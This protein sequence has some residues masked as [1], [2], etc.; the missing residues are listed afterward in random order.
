MPFRRL[1]PLTALR[2]FEAVA[3]RESIKDAADELCV[4][5]GAVSQQIRKLEEDLGMPLLIRRN[6]AIEVTPPARVLA[7]GLTDALS[8]IREAV[9]AAQPNSDE[10]CLVVACPPAFAMKWLVPRLCTF[11]DAHPDIDLRMLPHD[12]LAGLAVQGADVQI[13]LGTEPAE[14]LESESLGEETF[15][16]LMSPAFA[17][18]HGIDT[19]ADLLRVPLVSYKH[20]GLFPEAPTWVD[21]FGARH[22]PEPEDS[23]FFGFG[24]QVEQAID[25]AVSGLGAVL[26]P[27]V[28]AARDLAA[29]RLVAPWGPELGTGLSYEIAWPER[30]GRSANVRAFRQWLVSEFTAS[31]EAP[32]SP[33]LTA[34]VA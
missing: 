32:V 20:D 28:L 12:D 11:V 27:Q 30:L 23:R 17:E 31:Q 33:G 24:G 29:G 21:W 10:G 19:P 3:R 16:P 13:R 9:Q 5:P 25:A 6:R 18:R 14:G 15:I 1:P 34:A 2:A 7:A 22:L 26:G 8:R 4:T